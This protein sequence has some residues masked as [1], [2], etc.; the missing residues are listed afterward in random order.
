M[1]LPT[2]KLRAVALASLAASL[3]AAAG[4]WALADGERPRPQLGLLTTLPIY[5]TETFDPREAIDKAAPPHWARTALEEHYRLVPLDML[6]DGDPA[7]TELDHLLLA[8]PRALSPAENVALDDWVRAGGQVLIFADP[9]L[10][11]P[12]R[13]SIGDRRRPQD[14]ILLSP[15]LRR[16]GLELEFDPDQPAGERQILMQGTEVPVSQAGAF[17]KVTSSAPADCAIEAEGL[18]AVCTIGTGQAVLVADAA[19]LD[20]ARASAG[21]RPALAA[22]AERAFRK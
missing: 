2:G 21:P 15:I 20:Q 17:S 8:Q 19:L 9:M 16:W 1:P 4:V 6:D 13:F 7:L 12:S 14:V 18:V 5:W 10:T 22:L 3:A 11:A